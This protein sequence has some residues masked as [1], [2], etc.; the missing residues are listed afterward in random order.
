M[1][2]TDPASPLPNDPEEVLSL[3]ESIRGRVWALTMAVAVMA[4]SLLLTAAAVFGSLVNYFGGDVMLFG[5]ISVGAAVL[6]FAFGWA[7]RRSA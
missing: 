1:T 7:A 5:G 2:M 6:G 4:L 3:L